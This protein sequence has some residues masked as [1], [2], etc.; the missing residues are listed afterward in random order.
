MKTELLAT[1]ETRKEHGGTWGAR[2]SGLLFSASRRKLLHRALRA[3]VEKLNPWPAVLGAPPQPARCRVGVQALACW[4]RPDSLKAELQ[5]AFQTRALPRSRSCVPAFLI[6]PLPGFIR[7]SSVAKIFAVA[8]LSACTAFAQGPPPN[9]PP[10]ANY[11]QAGFSGPGYALNPG[12]AGSVSIYTGTLFREVKDLEV[13]GGVGEHQLVFSR[14]YSSRFN[15]SSTRHF[16]VSNW[17]HSYQWEMADNGADLDIFYP[18]GTRNKF[19]SVGGSKWTSTAAVPDVLWQTNNIYTLQ[20]P[21]GWQYQFAKLT[22]AGTIYY[23]MQSFNDS[24]ANQ[25]AFTYDASNR[26]T[27][28]TEPAGRYLELTFTNNNRINQVQ[29]SD[30]RKVT[31]TY[32]AVNA[33]YYPGMYV[34]ATAGYGDGTQADYTSVGND[35][36]GHLASAKDPRLRGPRGNVSYTYA[37]VMA[38]YISKETDISSTTALTTVGYD[39]S[40]NASVTNASGN[41]VGATYTS[42]GLTKTLG[43][44]LNRTNSFGYDTSGA[45]YLTSVTNALGHVTWFTNSARGNP[46]AILHP[47]SALDTVREATRGVKLDCIVEAVGNEATVDL[48]LRLVKRRGTVSVIGVQQARRYAFPLERAFAAGLTFRIGTCSVPEELPALFPLVQSGRLRPERY[49]THHLPLSAG[50]DAYRMFDARENG[51]LKMVLRPD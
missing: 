44:P 26:A 40:G 32:A 11:S 51:A 35:S 38:G 22:N 34:L 43:D 45:G 49:I 33:F 25:Y 15:S 10:G 21:K 29:A 47:D 31:Y 20:T 9:P 28:I 27:R 14:V 7:V 5:L 46:L 42:G 3:V 16:G 12:G 17:R 8:V 37:D 19:T 2:A 4:R 50:P 13:F 23:Q 30:G 6:N 24:R 41:K 18:D 39:A 36:Q 48:A 1:D